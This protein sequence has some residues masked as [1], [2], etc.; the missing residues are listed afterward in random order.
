MNIV[1]L[2]CHIMRDLIEVIK[3]FNS[4]WVCAFPAS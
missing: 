3:E 2:Y 1:E 4:S